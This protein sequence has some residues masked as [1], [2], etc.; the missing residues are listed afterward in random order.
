MREDLKLRALKWGL[1]NTPE[2]AWK[3]QNVFREK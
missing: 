1:L 3:T 2:D